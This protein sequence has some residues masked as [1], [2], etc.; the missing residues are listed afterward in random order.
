MYY[1][2]EKLL[3]SAYTKRKVFVPL[4]ICQEDTTFLARQYSSL[5]FQEFRRGGVTI[6]MLKKSSCVMESRNGVH[7]IGK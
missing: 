7:L 2:I 6:R 3:W 4:K 5:K 1:S